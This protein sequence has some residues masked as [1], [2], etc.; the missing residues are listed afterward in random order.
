VESILGKSPLCEGVGFGMVRNEPIKRERGAV[1]ALGTSAWLLLLPP[2]VV[3]AGVALFA[4]YPAS[5]G[6]RPKDEAKLPVAP[7]STIAKT[8]SAAPRPDGMLVAT[9]RK[10]SRQYAAGER[11]STGQYATMQKTSERVMEYPDPFGAP[12]PAPNYGPVAVTLVR[13]SKAGAPPVMAALGPPPSVAVNIARP[14]HVS[15]PSMARSHTFHAKSRI[16]RHEPRTVHPGTVHL[17]KHQ[18]P[19]A[20]VPSGMARGRTHRG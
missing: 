12:D 9:E 20:H 15:H 2:L 17:A 4:Y 14:P 13:V 1:A 19:H 6:I 8:V 5:G 16:G 11:V 18:R 3:V 7:E 10:S